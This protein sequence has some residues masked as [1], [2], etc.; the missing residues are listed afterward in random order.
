MISFKLYEALSGVGIFEQN[1][2]I[3]VW[4]QLRRTVDS[5]RDE[6]SFPSDVSQQL[7][8]KKIDDLKT[9]YQ[10]VSED[11][12]LGNS[13][14]LCQIQLVLKRFLLEIGQLDSEPTAV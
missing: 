14:I 1:V 8:Q 10:V 9:L 2:D 6:G 7:T 12:S 3:A 5:A 4:R 11:E 13:L